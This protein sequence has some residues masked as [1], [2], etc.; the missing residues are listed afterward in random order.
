MERRRRGLER[1][2]TFLVNHPILRTDG[3]LTAFL[4]EQSDLSAWRKSHPISLAEESA[5]RALTHTEEAAIPADLDDKL[6]QLRA[7]LPALVDHGTRVTATF[8]RIAHRR[9]NQGADWLRLR[10]GL[11]GARSAEGEGWRVRE[12]E[13]VERDEGV[14]AKGAGSVGDGLQGS[15][16]RA[17]DGTTEDLKRVRVIA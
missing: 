3:L 1:F 6:A 10:E 15:A 17:I 9:L 13:E 16:R 5:S 2:L 4:T 14:V 8:D 7:R 12:V 11:D